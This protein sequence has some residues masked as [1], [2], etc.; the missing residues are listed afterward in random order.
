MVQ[1]S[2]RKS[3]KQQ[4]SGQSKKGQ[5]LVNEAGATDSFRLHPLASGTYSPFSRNKDAPL[6]G[7]DSKRHSFAAQK[8]PGTSSSKRVPTKSASSAGCTGAAKSATAT[9][10]QQSASAGKKAPK[11]SIFASVRKSQAAA[12]CQPIAAPALM[13]ATANAGSREYASNGSIF[14]QD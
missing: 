5:S 11:Q 1:S 8:G 6:S 14:R 13:T 7:L 12:P 3:L 9:K 10:K 2:S 4:V